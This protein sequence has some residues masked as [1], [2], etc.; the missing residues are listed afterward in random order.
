M[1]ARPRL[2]PPAGAAEDTETSPF[3]AAE[4]EPLLARTIPVS[5]QLPR[6]RAPSA[7]R[8]PTAATRPSGAGPSAAFPGQNVRIDLTR[9]MP[10]ARGEFTIFGAISDR[11]TFVDDGDFPTAVRTLLGR[12][13]TI[14]M[15]IGPYANW[16]IIEGTGAYAFLHGRGR[17]AGLYPTPSASR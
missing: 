11:G 7:R 4:H 3:Q 14:R 13:G 8:H 6:Y 2:A 16:E 9:T 15:T 5:A 17:E 12:N 1:K 10:P